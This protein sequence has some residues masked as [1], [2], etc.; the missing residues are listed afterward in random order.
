[1]GQNLI[2]AQGGAPQKPTR[3]VSLFTSRFMVGMYTNRS[4]L[5]GPLSFLY[6]DYYHA[7]ATDALC[8]GL[9]SEL[10]IRQTM[11]RRPGNP[12]FCTVSTAAAIDNFYA[13]HHSDGT[14]QVIAD[15]ATDVEVITPSTNTSIFTKTSGAG[16]GYFQGIDKSMYIADGVDLVKYIPGTTNPQ[17]GKPIWNWGGVAPTVAPIIGAVRAT[18]GGGTAGGQGWVANTIFSTMGLIVDAAGNV[19][20]LT[21]VNA[22]GS[23]TTQFGTSSSGAPVFSTT[24]T[25]TVTEGGGVGPITWTCYGPIVTWTAGTKFNNASSISNNG[26]SCIIY[27]PVSQSCYWQGNGSGNATTGPVKPTFSGVFGS[28]INDGGCKWFCLGNPK[29]P[30]LWLPGHV[31][32]T[33][34]TVSFNNGVSGVVSPVTCAAAGLGTANAQTVYWQVA[35]SGGTSDSS[36]AHPTWA[37]SLGSPTT[38]DGDLVWNFLGSATRANN[39]TYFPWSASATSFGVIKETVSAVDYLYV[40]QSSTGPTAGSAPS[41]AAATL[42]GQT[43]QDGT[44]PGTQTFVGVTWVCVGKAMTWAATTQWYYPAGG[45]TPPLSSQNYGGA[46]IVGTSNTSTEYVVSSGKSGAGPEPTWG[47]QG[48]N[49]TDNGITWYNLQIFTSAGFTWT[50]GFGWC[51]AFKARLATDPACTDAPPLQIPGTN[52]PNITGPLGPPTGCGDGTVTTASPVSQLVGSNATGGQIPITLTGSTDPQFDTIVLFRSTDGFGAGGP[53]LY[54]TD[55]PMPP[56]NGNQ[57]G[58]VTIYDFMPDVATNLLPGLDPLISAPVDHAN[59]P[60]PGQ[61]GSTQFVPASAATPQVAMAGTAAI[62]PVYH[63]GRLWCFVGN[64]VFASTGPDTDTGNGFTAWN[65]TYE[66]PFDSNVTRLIPTATALL[67]FTTT[68]AYLI[69]G[70]PAIADYYSQLLAPGVGLLSYNAVTMMMGLPYLFT[71]DRQYVSVDPSGGFT[72]IGHPIGDKL[73]S[74]DP[75]LVYTAYHSF[76][77]NEH[78]LFIS[79]GS[80]EWYRCDPYPAPDSQMTGPIWSPK[81][82]ISGGFKAI[83]S[84]ET[85]PGVRQLLIGPPSAGYILNRDSTFTTFTDNGS[86]YA[87]YFTIGNIVLAHP[88]QMAECAFVAMD[89]QKVGT[90][91]TVSVLFDELSATNGAAFESISNTILSDPP[92]KYGPTGTPDTMWMNRYN[93]GQTTPANGGDQVPV[94]AWCK[95]MQLKVDFGNTDTVQNELMAFSIFGALYQEK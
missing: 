21:G 57:P 2:Q 69:G 6:S 32:P 83:A 33:V 93:F 78:A 16:Q 35:T 81:A 90:Q 1:M 84:I 94:P 53:Y 68:D 17:T 92:K 88:G 56:M 37:T 46:V 23:N 63:Q 89:F 64:S 10:S 31:Y 76:G 18:T 51:Y 41:F 48:T 65:P 3:F 4:L 28:T 52:S 29:V 19:Q 70:G 43:V 15:S 77:D 9:N 44:N 85:S 40:C 91:P 58:T 36:G 7:G 95:S 80:T 49:T 62:G 27:D 12:K 66:F 26:Q 67:V 30:A 20:Q 39:A 87:S 42:Y 74:Y 75:T 45:F 59:D 38:F 82:T 86:A 71:S 14:I 5:R 13:F 24:T 34:S 72:R 25:G 73:N 47:A 55:I 61:F 79:N 22:T 60:P 54:E 8:D 11:I 50:K